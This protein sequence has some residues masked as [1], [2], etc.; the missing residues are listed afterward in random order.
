M[1]SVRKIDLPGG[2]LLS[3]YTT[4]RNYTDC[5]RLVIEDEVTLDEYIYAFYTTWLFKIERV[6]LRFAVSKPSTKSEARRLADGSIEYFAAWNVEDRR[7]DQI[8]MC[9]FH[10]RTRSWLM[11]EP[12]PIGHGIGTQLFFG[13][14]VVESGDAR[15]SLLLGFHKLYSRALLSTARS[16]VKRLR[17][18]KNG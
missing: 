8:L 2:A 18:R 9:D 4:S 1:F 7:S 6:I 13:S 10:K 14:A 17:R 12:L 11:V 16:R 15:F 3:R 5:F